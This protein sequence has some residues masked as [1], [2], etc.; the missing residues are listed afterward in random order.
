MKWQDLTL[1]SIS[2]YTE[3]ERS[4]PQKGTML[5]YLRTKVLFAP[6]DKLED[7]QARIGDQEIL[8]IHLFDDELEYRAISS[9]SKRFSGKIEWIADFPEE[10]DVYVQKNRLEQDAVNET[11]KKEMTVLNHLSYDANGMLAMDDFR[12]KL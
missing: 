6:Y 1:K 5:V 8:E 11:G 10:Q 7:V 2:P 4:A 12:M 9:L 3:K